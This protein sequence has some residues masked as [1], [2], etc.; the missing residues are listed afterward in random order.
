[1]KREQIPE[2][3]HRLGRHIWHDPRSRQYPA[4]VAP[5]VTTVHSRH[6]PPFDQGNLGSCTGNAMA[7]LLMTDPFWRSGRALTEADA[8]A[9]YSDA[10]KI[11]RYAGVYPPT[12]TG[13]SG[14]AVAKAA[15][16]RGYCTGY[17]HAF[18]LQHA[19]GALVIAPVIIGINWYDSFDAPDR[20]GLI[21]ISPNA[22]VRGGHE[23]VTR[24]IDVTNHLVG[25]D[26]SWG[27]RWG[28]P[29]PQRFGGWYQM[30]WD[31]FLRLLHEGGDVTTVS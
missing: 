21:S 20:E 17:R 30:T 28:A 7:G 31:T 27:P 18:G 1:M 12:D 10:T 29:G 19:L 25:G 8:V 22:G 3:Q 2:T 6:C 23:L 13:S 26:Q 14:L 5:L 9:L 11:D 24:A 15:K 4:E 16:K